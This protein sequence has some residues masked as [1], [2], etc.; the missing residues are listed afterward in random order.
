VSTSDSRDAHAV[1][2]TSSTVMLNATDRRR[3]RFEGGR[4]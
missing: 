2:D 4:P 1:I 3:Q